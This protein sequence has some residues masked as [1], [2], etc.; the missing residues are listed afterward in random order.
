MSHVKIKNTK[1]GTYASWV[2]NF[3]HVFALIKKFKPKIK[4]LVKI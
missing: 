3:R 2:K 1:V 4:S